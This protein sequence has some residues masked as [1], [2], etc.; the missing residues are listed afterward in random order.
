[1]AK[2]DMTKREKIGYIRGF[3]DADGYISAPTNTSRQIQLINVEKALLLRIQGYLSGFGIRSKLSSY[4]PK[5]ENCRV[6]YRLI[7]TS[8]RN[9]KLWHKII[10][11]NHDKKKRRLQANVDLYKSK[12][13]CWWTLHERKRALEMQKQGYSIKK[14]RRYFSNRTYY[15]VATML[16]KAKRGL[17]K[18]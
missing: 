1:M 6:V 16:S 2:R 14:I 8:V 3:A 12:G 18:K 5:R 4:Q 9:L 7:I 17:Y 10:G 13:G 11:F 15:S